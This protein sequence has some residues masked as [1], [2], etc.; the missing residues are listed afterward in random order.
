M[1]LL[2]LLVF[3]PMVMALACYLAGRRSKLLRDVLVMLT[4]AAAFAGCLCTLAGE[5]SFT[6][7]GFCGFG[8]HLRA[9]GFRSLYASIAAFMWMM[10][11]VFSREYFA[12]YRNRNRYYFFN[13]ITLGATLGVFLSDDLY[14][15]F[16]FFEVMSL[17]SYPW[18]AQE[19]TPGAM[20][21]AGTYL[22]VAVIGGLTTLM[23]VFLMWLETGTLAFGELRGALGGE[24]S[25][26]ATVATWLVLVGFAAKAGLFPL[27]IWLP[28]AHPV[29]PAPASALL[30][31][32]LTKSG[33]FGLIVICAQLMPGNA[34]FGNALLVLAAITMFLGAL[35]A[36]FSV[37]LKRTLAC[38]SMSQIGFI[39]VG[40]SMMVLLGEHG[41]LAAYGTVM[42][43]MNH[44]LIKLVLFMCAGVIY[45]NLHRLNL[46]DIRGFGRRKPVLHAV[47]LLG[48]LSIA[49]VPPIGSGYVSKSLLHEAILELVHHLQEHGHSALPYQALEILFLISGGL[50]VAY[51]TK[52]YV[53]IF[54]EKHPTRQEE[55]DG[56]RKYAGLPSK[57]VLVLSALVL[58]ALCLLPERLMT[59]VGARSAAFFGQEG[60]HH[61]IEYYCSANLIGAAQSIG[62]GVA[63]YLLI[64]RPLLMRREEGCRV[65]VDRWP[66]RLDLEE[67]VYRPVLLRFL[68]GVLGA[69]TGFIAGIPESKLVT[70]WIPRA[71]TAVVR[72]FC[73]LPEYIVMLLRGTAFRKVRS[74]RAVPV[75]NRLTYGLGTALNAIA[76]GLN[77]TVLRRRPMRTDFEYVLDASWREF[78]AGTHRVTAS[79]SFGLLLMCIGLYITCMYL[80]R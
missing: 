46:N 19:E 23:G 11:G 12:H 31:G 25:L 28:K 22:A 13:L 48:A 3:G 50:T 41:S 9:D 15:T 17:A 35:L 26:R 70:E 14:T 29:A 62:I 80:L 24:P 5:A 34:A 4:G 57:A 58:P 30:S 43:M 79:V 7:D 74:R 71:V 60:V 63:V 42:H 18:V 78:T 38:S 45:M 33:V 8:L 51:M 61:A 67:A 20:R 39:T 56:M 2:P 54:W 69:V 64:V 53:C 76:R 32:I 77:A 65:Y 37:D 1:F 27:H 55:F 75:G 21:A 49:C 40:L 73:E 52:L 72:F 10:S 44:S 36:L 59:P 47:F 68:P 16:I 6:L 66:A